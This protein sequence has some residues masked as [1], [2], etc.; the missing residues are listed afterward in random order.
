[1]P[2]DDSNASSEEGLVDIDDL[3]AFEEEFYQKPKADLDED[4]PVEETPKK[5]K[6]VAEIEEDHLADDDDTDASEDENPAEDEDDDEDEADE[7]KP[8]ERPKSK[9]QKRIE[10]LLER[11]RLANERATALEVRLAALEAP[12]KTEVPDKETPSLRGQLPDDAPNPDATDKDGNPI[13]PLGEFDPKFVFDISKYSVGIQLAEAEA[14]KNKEAEAVKM[15]QAQTEIREGW[16]DR[17]DKAEETLPEIRENIA[18]LVETFGSLEPAYGEYLAT[19]IMANDRGPEIMNY[20]SQNIG[21]AQR[22][23]AS[24]PTAAILAIG[25]LEARLTPEDKPEEKRNSKRQS[26]APNPPE[27]RSRGSGAKVSVSADTDDQD[28]FEREF[29]KK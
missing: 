17:L 25:R 8:V 22:I 15:E 21:E 2:I 24:G 9:T 7:P 1:M 20:L 3:N 13:Y 6:D 10:K 26:N 4:E 28:A 19:A 29:F 5:D 11:E 23:V 16:L 27:A 18:E 12:K 14:R